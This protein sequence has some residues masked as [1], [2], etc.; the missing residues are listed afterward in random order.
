MDTS[1]VLGE[2]AAAGLTMFPDTPDTFRTEDGRRVFLSRVRRKPTPANVVDDLRRVGDED[3]VLYIVDRVTPT[4]AKAAHD[5]GRLIVFEQSSLSIWLDGSLH[6]ALPNKRTRAVTRGRRPYGQF[7]VA[8]ALLLGA[9][10]RKQADLA[11]TLGLTQSG[12]SQAITRLGDLV[13][14]THA[15]ITAADPD[16][17]LCFC[18]DDYPGPGGMTTYWWHDTNLLAQASAFRG[19]PGAIVSGD[20]AASQVYAWRKPEHVTVYLEAG[21]DPA[22]LGFAMAS[23]DDYTTSVTVPADRTIFATAKAFGVGAGY[24]DA[25][26]T[27]WDVTSTGTTGDQVEAADL[28]WNSVLDINRINENT[29]SG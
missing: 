24:A 6:L 1:H 15:G 5:D 17:L 4:L 16:A 3:R 28:V 23:S 14:T 20:L 8:R 7:A 11:E 18:R 10:F 13:E 25:I 2:L 27:A 26:L 19:D 12:V 9:P 22:R 21:I 29:T